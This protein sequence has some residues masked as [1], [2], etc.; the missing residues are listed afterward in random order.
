[1]LDP[2]ILY[3]SNG[4]A[5]TVGNILVLKKVEYYSI[6]VSLSILV[7]PNSLLYIHFSTA[8]STML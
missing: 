2:I 5:Q 1:M 8:T 4:A 6:S 7:L 3:I